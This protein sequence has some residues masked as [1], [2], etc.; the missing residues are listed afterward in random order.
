MGDAIAVG[1][2]EMAF[3]A[4]AKSGTRYY[5]HPLVMQI[6]RAYERDASRRETTREER[7]RR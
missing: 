6:V 4:L 7:K 3:S 2:P 5:R 1:G